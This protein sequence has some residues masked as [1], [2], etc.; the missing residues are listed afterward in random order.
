MKILKLLF[1][2][3]KGV[4]IGAGFAFTTILFILSLSLRNGLAISPKI[5]LQTLTSGAY[6]YLWGFTLLIFIAGNLTEQI[7]KGIAWYKTKGN[8]QEGQHQ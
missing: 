1:G 7:S 8:K 2:A 5:D 6:I 4:I 3:S